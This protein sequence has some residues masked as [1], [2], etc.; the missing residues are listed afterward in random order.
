M[1]NHVEL[2]EVFEV[3]AVTEDGTRHYPTPKGNY[4]SVTT[5]IGKNPEKMAGIMRWRK[6]VGEE[7]ANK[8]SKRAT[9]RGNDFH[10]FTEHYL[11]NNHPTDD[12]LTNSPLSA[13][14]FGA[15][16]PIL[17]NI[18]NIYLQEAV[19]YSDLLQIAGRVDCIAEYKGELSIID[20]KTSTKPKKESYIYDYFVQEQAYACMFYEMYGL[21]VDKLVT[22]IAC[23][24]LDV[25]VFVRRPCKEYFVK[26]KEYIAH[27]NKNYAG[28]PG[29]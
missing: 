25:Q 3:E 17:N 9:S 19:L 5:V 10:L 21:A 15:A 14:M 8:V 2:A 22:I 24:D 20:F 7:K 29:G 23:E 26:L 18:N 4:P 27:Y 6:R 12:A 1:F 11:Q 16:I 28:K 13:M